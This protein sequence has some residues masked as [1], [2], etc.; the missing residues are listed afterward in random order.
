MHC[1]FHHQR[2]R[3]WH[4]TPL[5]LFEE[6]CLLNNCLFFPVFFQHFLASLWILHLDYQER[7]YNNQWVPMIIPISKVV[8]EINKNKG[9][10]TTTKNKQANNNSNNSLPSWSLDKETWF[11]HFLSIWKTNVSM[12]KIFKPNIWPLLIYRYISF[13]PILLILIRIW[14]KTH[15]LMS[16]LGTLDTIFIK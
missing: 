5:Y 15:I 11:K 8:N 3:W 6:C 14:V 16:T 13:C 12:L 4:I 2:L 10:K 9:H 7:F 1:H